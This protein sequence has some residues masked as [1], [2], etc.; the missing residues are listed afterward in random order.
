MPSSPLKK[1]TNINVKAVINSQKPNE[2]IAKAVP[3]LFVDKYPRKIP[4]NS[5]YQ[6]KK[7]LVKL[8]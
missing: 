3:N 6:I 4:K 5:R 1:T 8:K 7:K 2:I